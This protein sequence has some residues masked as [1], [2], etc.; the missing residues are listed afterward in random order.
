MFKKLKQ[1]FTKSQYI[2]VELEKEIAPQEITSELRESAKTLQFH[3]AF[4]YIMHRIKAEKAML[5]KYLHEGFTLPEQQLHHLQAGIY[6][7]EFL[8][9]ELRKLTSMPSSISREATSL[10]REEFEK[11]RANLDLVG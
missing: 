9:R 8:D 1:Y 4:S 10:E 11:I 5:Q 7:L 6:Y 2:V 3:P